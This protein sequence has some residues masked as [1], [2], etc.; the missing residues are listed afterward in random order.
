MYPLPGYVF[1]QRDRNVGSGGGVGIFLKHEIRFKRRFDLENHLE[2]LWIEIY[3][4][5][6]KSILTLSRRRPLSHRN[7][8]IDLRSSMDWFL[9]DNGLCLER[10]KGTRREKNT[11]K[12]NSSPYE[13]YEYGHL[14]RWYIKLILFKRF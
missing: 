4:K 8:S 1:L 6:S 14:G 3:F 7:Q 12:L 2:T 10:V 9:Y 11:L 5:N 13:K